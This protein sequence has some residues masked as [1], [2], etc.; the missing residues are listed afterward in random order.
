MAWCHDGRKTWWPYH[1]MVWWRRRWWWRQWWWCWLH[2]PIFIRFFFTRYND[3]DDDDD[4]F[5]G[6]MTVAAAH[7]WWYFRLTDSFIYCFFRMSHSPQHRS[8]ASTGWSKC[9]GKS[10]SNIFCAFTM[11]AEQNFVFPTNSHAHIFIRTSKYSHEF[12]H[13]LRQIPLTLHKMNE[14]PTMHSN[15]PYARPMTRV[16]GNI[17]L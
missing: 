2:F 11:E 14:I 5:G 3:D 15:V 6:T 17:S 13:K 9:M 10:M 4:V 8:C 1:M 7:M 12:S 16:H